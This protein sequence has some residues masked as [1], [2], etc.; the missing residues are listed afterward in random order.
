MEKELFGTDGIRGVAGQ[1][2]L[3][4][5]TVFAV[6]LSLGQ[7]LRRK[8]ARGNVILGEDTRESSHWIA[9]TVAAG[10]QETAREVVG[11]GVI[12][13]PGLAY[14]TASENFAAGIMISASHN[15]YQDNGIKI[16]AATGF[17][18]PEEDE[19][20]ITRQVCRM[21]GD[22]SAPQSYALSVPANPRLVNRYVDFLRRA[23]GPSWSLPGWK[24]ILDCANGSASAIAKEVF[25]GYGL[26]VRFL[27]DRPNGQNINLHCG[28]LH[29]ETLQEAVLRE[30]ADLGA[31][32]DGDADRALF[33]A[34][35]GHLVN[36]DGILWAASRS[37]R[38]H[39][40]L[41]GGAVVG[42]V[43]TNLG[44]EHALAREGLKLLRTPVGDKYVLDEMLR[45]GA[46]LGGEQS[47]HIIFRDLATTGDGLLTVLQVLRLLAERK[48]PLEE[49]VDGLKFFPQTIRNVRVREKAPL[50]SLPQVI[51]QIQ[52]G[53]KRLGSSGRLL[54]RYS[55]T[56][57]L[58]RVM[59]EAE[60]AEEVEQVAS[61]I[62]RALEES[63]GAS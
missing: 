12:T 6:G 41:Q 10:L 19:M 57:S 36:G 35:N 18:L 30:K 53:E 5:A 43:M 61:A 56:E 49:L 24:L 23:A 44:L 21:L 47:G 13:T 45:S 55:G 34:A 39:G 2:P 51:E 33:V 54:V 14:L 9:E 38:E 1:P 60:S 22:G 50:E 37:M 4:L 25:S 46:N 3:D 26:E 31:A 52:A 16:I 42:T 11:V 29:M 7:L 59:V 8:A 58:V 15:P 28:S 17:K 62:A 27:G 48:R 32:L 63:L 20:E 40:T